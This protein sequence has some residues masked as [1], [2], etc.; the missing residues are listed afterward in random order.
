MIIRIALLLLVVG[1]L[2]QAFAQDEVGLASDE[3]L[4]EIWSFPTFLS[5]PKSKKAVSKDDARLVLSKYNYSELSRRV[6][7]KA[8][9]IFAFSYVADAYSVV[10]P[11]STF[12]KIF[13]QSTDSTRA[14]YLE[15]SN[16][17]FFHRGWADFAWGVNLSASFSQGR[18]MFSSGTLSETQF[19]LWTVPVEPFLMME[20]PVG[21]W[22]KLGTSAGP[23]AVALFQSRNDMENGEKYKHR[24]QMGWGYFAT[25]KLKT[26]L[27]AIY[28]EQGFNFFSKYS[29]TRF[30][31]DLIVK[32]RSYANFQDEI[33]I[34]GVSWGAGFSF[35][36][37]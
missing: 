18:G 6:H 32:L 2:P 17:R 27:A 20:V 12:Q 14:G 8:D 10:S 33:S 25:L 30:H 26:D 29:I 35:E 37:L 5:E 31:L 13:E 28:P 1:L 19:S 3:E 11:N 36:F 15:I 24:R 7:G 23:S 22:F 9:S 21:S 34:S 4:Q 16:G